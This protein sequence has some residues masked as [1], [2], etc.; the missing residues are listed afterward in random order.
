MPSKKYRVGTHAQGCERPG[1]LL[2]AAGDGPK[3]RPGLLLGAAGDG[4][5]DGP[6]EEVPDLFI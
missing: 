6:A 3:E 5:E 1:L 4:P 2:G